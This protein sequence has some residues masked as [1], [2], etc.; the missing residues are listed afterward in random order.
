MGWS[1]REL[2]VNLRNMVFMRKL[3]GVS[4]LNTVEALGIVPGHGNEGLELDRILALWGADSVHPTQAAY[5]ILA[6]I[7]EDVILEA[8]EPLPVV[9]GASGKRK[10]DQRETAPQRRRGGGP[11]PSLPKGTNV[12][13]PRSP[14]AGKIVPPNSTPI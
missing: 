1:L 4:V 3:S 11:L 9:G 5:R 14:Y 7:A 8:S 10:V 12:A 13:S 6:E 2:T